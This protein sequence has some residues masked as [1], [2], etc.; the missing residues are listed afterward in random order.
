MTIKGN[1][2]IKSTRRLKYCLKCKKVYE[3]DSFYRKKEI[4]YD[5]MPTY[6]LP[7]ALCKKCKNK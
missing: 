4:H 2:Y 6:G 7:R 1:Q 5:G 3:I